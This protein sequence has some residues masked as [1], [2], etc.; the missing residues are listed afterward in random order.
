MKTYC[1]YIHCKPNGDPFYVGKAT[2][3]A[4][5][6]NNRPFMF[7]HRNPM[8]KKIVAKYGAKSIQVFLFMCET[9]AEALAS[10]IQHIAQ[11][12]REGFTLANLTDGGEGMSGYQPS[13]AT[14][15]T[16]SLTRKG[17]K[18]SDETREKLSE[19]RRGKK[20]PPRTQEHIEKIRAARTGKKQGPHSAEHRAALSLAHTGKIGHAHSEATRQKMSEAQRGKKMPPGAL[21]KA[22][23]TRRRNKSLKEQ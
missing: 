20:M 17:R 21:Q 4:K 3:D 16:W 6:R 19:V 14:R 9:E 7:S 13:E 10:E 1:N 2:I 8:H 12:R 15:K 5:H 23:E 22:W 18:A 11:F